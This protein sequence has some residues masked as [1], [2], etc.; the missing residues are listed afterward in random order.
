MLM[1]QFAKISVRQ[2]RYI[3]FLLYGS[4]VALIVKHIAVAKDLNKKTLVIKTD[5]LGD[6]YIWR[7]VLDN[8]DVKVVRSNYPINGEVVGI[9]IKKFYL[10][11]PYMVRV[12][13]K[14]SGSYER[15]FLASSGKT[16]DVFILAIV[17]RG[18]KECIADHN[19]NFV[20][21]KFIERRFFDVIHPDFGSEILN[22][23]RFEAS[24]RRNPFEKQFG[25]ILFAPYASTKDK[26]IRPEICE[27][28]L[29]ILSMGGIEVL[30][31][32]DK[33]D[34]NLKK[35]FDVATFN[36]MIGV[37]LMSVEK[38]LREILSEGWLFV[39]ADSALLHLY[40]DILSQK[41][42][43]IVFTGLGYPGRFDYRGD[44]LVYNTCKFSGCRWQCHFSDYNCTQISLKT[45]ED[46]IWSAVK[47][48]KY[49]SRLENPSGKN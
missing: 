7:S 2:L 1:L 5:R 47:K 15:V 40:H 32:S 12:L 8:F 18:V 25:K 46:L 26:S 27:K 23:R 11:F 4:A 49:D 16:P 30:V 45:V 19:G 22:A 44:I 34:Y 9:N 41:S 21:S 14:L 43:A 28:I 38:R 31:I 17:A 3:V 36:W 39:G 24:L 33:D 42:R 29:D 10:S 20:L 48:S 6:H 37:D 35:R 13:V